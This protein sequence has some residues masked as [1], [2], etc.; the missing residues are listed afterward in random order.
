[1]QR[2]WPRP[3]GGMRMGVWINEGPETITQTT[4]G[5]ST[6][7]E[8]R[9]ETNSKTIHVPRLVNDTGGIISFEYFSKHGPNRN[10]LFNHRFLNK[11]ASYEESSVPNVNSKV[12]P[13]D[14]K[15]D[16][17]DDRTLLSEKDVS[18]DPTSALLHM[19]LNRGFG[20]MFDVLRFDV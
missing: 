1:M 2:G 3:T 7:T 18:E 12:G 20:H 11:R 17:K 13:N 6:S 15:M 5:W 8:A 14:V 9:T 4:C 10:W 19:A 16:L